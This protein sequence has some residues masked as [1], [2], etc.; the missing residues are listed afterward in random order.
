LIWPEHVSRLER[1]DAALAEAAQ[2]KP[3]VIVGDMVDRLPTALSEVD[4]D[5]APVVFASH[6]ITYLPRDVQ[7]QLVEALSAIGAERDLAVVLNEA[8]RCGI[9]LFS[10]DAP[11]DDG[12]E[13]VSTLTLVEWRDGT[14]SVTSLARTGPHGAWI[15]WNPTPLPYRPASPQ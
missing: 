9:Q 15:A 10:V 14:P 2:V 4:G 8:P 13:P 7:L 11:D 3:P 6:A 1:L 5:V 12:A